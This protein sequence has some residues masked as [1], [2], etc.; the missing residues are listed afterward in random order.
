VDKYSLYTK[1]FENYVSLLCAKMTLTD[2]A[3][4]AEIDWKAAKLI[5]KKYLSQLVTGLD[6]LNPRRLGIDE[7]A[8]EKGHSYLSVVRDLDIGR[9]IWAGQTRRKEALDAFFFAARR[10]E[11]KVRSRSEE[12]M[13]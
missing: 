7:I 1:R 2:A 12:A 11:R 10:R 6:D 5:D 9:V 3:S 8:Y 4:V 13:L